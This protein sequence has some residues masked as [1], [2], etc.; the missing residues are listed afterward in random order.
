MAHTAALSAYEPLTK[1]LQT[2]PDRIQRN[3]RLDQIGVDSLT[4]AELSTLTSRS[5]D[6]DLPVVEIAGAAGLPARPAPAR[7]T[8]THWCPLRR[9]SPTG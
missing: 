4:A 7:P 9:L 1:V 3:R 6:C 8:A 5:L 2:A